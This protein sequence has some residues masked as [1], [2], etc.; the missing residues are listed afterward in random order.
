MKSAVKTAKSIKMT[1]DNVTDTVVANSLTVVMD[2]ALNKALDLS[3]HSALS[4]ALTTKPVGVPGSSIVHETNL[5]FKATPKYAS[6]KLSTP[7]DLWIGNDA[8]PPS[9]A[10]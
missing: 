3:I 8:L 9:F 1:L 5:R 2:T 7:E 4:F 10:V 6:Q